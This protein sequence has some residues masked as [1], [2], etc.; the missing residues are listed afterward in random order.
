M[1]KTRYLLV[2]AILL[3]AV[4]T[5]WAIYRG[6]LSSIPLRI[7][8]LVVYAFL[9]IIVLK[10]RNFPGA[11]WIV[12][13]LAF[14]MVSVVVNSTSFVLYLF[15]IRSML[16]YYVIAAFISSET[17]EEKDLV[18][19]F[20]F[21]WI[22]LLLQIPIAIIKYFT[23][24]FGET[25]LGLC[26]TSWTTFIF[27]IGVSYCLSF[28]IYSHKKRYLLYILGFVLF[29][30]IGGKRAILYLFPG[31]LVFLIAVY[32]Y[33]AFLRIKLL[34]PLSVGILLITYAIVRFIPT[35]NPERKVGG[36]FDL[37]YVLEYTTEYNTA[38]VR[39]VG[40]IGRASA[41]EVAFEKLSE[42]GVQNI[43]FGNGAGILTKTSIER[44]DNR[45]V[46]K[47]QYDIGYG[48]T[49]LVYMLIQV[50]IIGS[51]VYFVFIVSLGRYSWALRDYEE[52]HFWKAFHLGTLGVV[53]SISF[54]AYFYDVI[55]KE[56]IVM[57]IVYTLIGISISRFNM[58]TSNRQV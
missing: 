39:G 48:V 51:L 41:L 10:K 13:C 58:I 27:L 35:L 17:S 57:S 50:G 4:L 43:L 3:L 38:T 49:A 53:L 44:F 30:I 5:G 16:L 18:D 22:L 8:E 24:G 12:I 6:L 31:I 33:R 25:P 1:L 46:V 55:H 32:N 7:I 11:I 56:P 40:A 19:L 45:N 23:I 37:S 14:W 52:D 28:Y 9:L 20:N 29:G 2:K 42:S 34:V 15:F 26:G 54:I 36:S 21:V 47:E